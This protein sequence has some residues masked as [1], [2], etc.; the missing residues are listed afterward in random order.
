M[1]N[2]LDDEPIEIVVNDWEQQYH[3]K[4]SFILKAKVLDEKKLYGIFEKLPFLE[5]Q[6]EDWVKEFIKCNLYSYIHGIGSTAVLGE[7]KVEDKAR[8]LIE[9]KKAKD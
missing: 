8:I 7:Q 4:I 6:V 3:L 1:D 5:E 2:K 9:L